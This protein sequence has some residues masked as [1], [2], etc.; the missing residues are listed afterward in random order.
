ML[1]NRSGYTQEMV[2]TLIDKE[3]VNSADYWGISPD[4]VVLCYPMEGVDKGWIEAA[5]YH[6]GTFPQIS[7]A[8]STITK[9][10][11][12]INYHYREVPVI[13][14]CMMIDKRETAR[15]NYVDS[16]DEGLASAKTI[17]AAAYL[18]Y[19][20]NSVESVNQ[21]FETAIRLALVS[22]LKGQQVKSPPR[23]HKLS[24]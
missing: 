8:F 3:S 23:R 13:L 14:V 17:N 12:Q 15:S 24:H 6:V 22:K 9:W 7:L 16:Y 19:S 18:E 1:M 21:M 11:P 2:L 10:F 4:V 20:L 5:T